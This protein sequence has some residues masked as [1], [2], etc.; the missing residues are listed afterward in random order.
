[1]YGYNKAFR[2]HSDIRAKSCSSP[3]L[4]EDGVFRAFYNI[5]S[6]FVRIDPSGLILPYICILFS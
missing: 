5:D 1:M 3:L 2:I 6:P 4:A